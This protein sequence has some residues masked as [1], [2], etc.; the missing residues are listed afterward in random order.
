MGRLINKSAIKRRLMEDGR[1]SDFIKVREAYK[2]EGVDPTE[3]WAKAAE[4][5]PPLEGIGG[6]VKAVK[7]A[8]RQR[9]CVSGE[10]N[11][12]KDGSGNAEDAA[13]DSGAEASATCA[14]DM[15]GNV[16]GHSVVQPQRLQQHNA[17]ASKPLQNQSDADLSIKMFERVGKIDMLEW[18]R[19]VANY[20]DVAD[21]TPD[22]A[23]APGAWAWLKRV[24][25]N[26]V[27]ALEFYR[28]VLPKLLPNK[29]QME[30]AER[31]TDDGTKTVELIDR[32]LQANSESGSKES[33][34]VLSGS[35]EGD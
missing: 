29:T 12:A 27:M 8:A 25:S 11:A 2:A 9:A 35:S 34:S 16:S 18:V 3:A 26:S 5:F 7:E 32:V 23:P 14:G 15:A 20:I 24:R 10:G 13:E 4:Q 33:G 22:M 21:V 1:W 30:E 31:F 19:F 17:I 6:E 28:L